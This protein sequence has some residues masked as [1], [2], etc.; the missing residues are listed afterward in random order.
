MRIAVPI[1]GHPDLGDQVA[2]RFCFAERAW[3]VEVADGRETRRERIALGRPSFPA[4]R[5]P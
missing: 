1:L 3:I 4:N 5:S 2:P